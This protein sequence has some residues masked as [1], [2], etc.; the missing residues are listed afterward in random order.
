MKARDLSGST[1]GRWTVIKLAG[2]IQYSSSRKT[3]WHCVCECGGKATVLGTS[4]TSGK[5]R[6]C[7]CLSSET[8]RSRTTKHGMYGSRV[9]NT[10]SNML[11]RCRNPNRPDYKHYGAAGIEVCSR[12]LEFGNFLTD[13]RTPAEDQVLARVD[14]TGDFCPD[15]CIWISKEQR[16]SAASR[17]AAAA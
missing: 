2:C 12:W 16:N 13:M 6:S 15:N 10:W 4:L 17:E 7:G 1:F 14:E 11:G 3:M 5:S 8:T 9:Y